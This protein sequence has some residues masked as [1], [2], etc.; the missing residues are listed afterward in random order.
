MGVMPTD[1][2]VA[3]DRWSEALDTFA[4]RL[5]GFR[6]VVEQDLDPR[7]DVWPDTDLSVYPIPTALV[8]RARALL[9]A[10]DEVE[11]LIVDA[12]EAA[13]PSQR[14]SRPR[15]RVTGRANF[16]TEL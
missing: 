16:L 8:P 14:S 10:A 6:A 12:R 1:E 9:K 3:T 15:R 4:S 13:Q 7:F 11:A 5:D 2:Q